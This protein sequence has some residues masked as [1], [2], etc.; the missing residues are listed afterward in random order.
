MTC[1]V[2]K[3]LRCVDCCHGINDV[4]GRHDE[5][6]THYVDMIDQ[7]TLGHQFISE[8]F[9]VQPRIGWQIGNE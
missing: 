6:T 9:G 5:A 8:E 7:T 3:R 1:P 2:V 4:C